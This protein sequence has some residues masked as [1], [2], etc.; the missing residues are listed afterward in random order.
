M[1]GR[2]I[3]PPPRPGKAWRRPPTFSVVI[4]VF[5]A[6]DTVG[7]AIESALDQ[8]VPPLEVIVCDDG[9]TDDIVDAI[10]PYGKD[11]IF[12]RQENMG[13][14]VARNRAVEAARGQIIA[15]LDAD[16]AFLPRRLAALRSVALARPDVE[17]I[18]TDA[19]IEVDGEFVGRI[20]GERQAFPI[21]GQ[22]TAIVI[23][24]F[25]FAQT[26]VHREWLLRVPFDRFVPPGV[27]DWL[28]WIGLILRGASA[29]LLLE[30]LSVYAVRGDSLSASQATMLRSSVS[31][32]E[33]AELDP[34][35]R[36]GEREVLAAAVARY[37]RE[38]AVAELREALLDARS[39]A[40]RHALAVA[41]GRGFGGRRRVRAAAAAVAPAVARY[42]VQRQRFRHDWRLSL[43]DV[44]S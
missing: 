3:A 24:N 20:Y 17:I 12:L 43:W 26:A 9:S 32:Y 33:R 21:E 18:T 14:A 4:P 23:S 10:A 36:A 34:A 6:A 37:R 30:P 25:I 1:T 28:C 42:L 2:L 41:C 15:F 8:T 11:V 19:Y 16:D 27:E 29:G 39:G 5:Q 7:R 22:R 13:P 31:L 35:L 44:R 38:L 40:R